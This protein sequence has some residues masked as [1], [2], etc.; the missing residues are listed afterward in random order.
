MQNAKTGFQQRQT[1]RVWAALEVMSSFLVGKYVTDA[2]PRQDMSR[3]PSKQERRL[4]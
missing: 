3:L 2:E 1:P 4:T